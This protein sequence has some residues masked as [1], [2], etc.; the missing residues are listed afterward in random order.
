MGSN[1][2]RSTIQFKLLLSIF[3]MKIISLDQLKVEIEKLQPLHLSAISA[4][5]IKG[6][7]VL[8]YHFI[9]GSRT[10]DFKIKVNYR[11]VVPSI[12]EIFPQAAYYEAE[13]PEMFGIKFDR[14][15]FKRL[16]LPDNWTGKPPLRVQK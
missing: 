11:T 2:T 7:F 9:K 4:D 14:L 10:L 13:I 12:S 6:G 16:F 3:L 8:I 5:N 15:L 1:P